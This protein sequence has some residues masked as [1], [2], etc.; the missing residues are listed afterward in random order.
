MAGHQVRT[1]RLLQSIG[2]DHITLAPGTVLSLP[3]DQAARFVRA[4]IAE[5][6]EPERAIV[7]PDET[8]DLRAR[9]LRTKP[10]PP[11]N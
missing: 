9:R 1:I 5:W 11:T 4:G 10:C 7:E 8:R 6:A 2:R 3:S